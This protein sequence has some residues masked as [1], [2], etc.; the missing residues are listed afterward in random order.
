M[1]IDKLKS[2]IN[3]EVKYSVDVGFRNDLDSFSQALDENNY[4]LDWR[5][6]PLG[7]IVSRKW[8]DAENNELLK[9]PKDIFERFINLIGSK[10]IPQKVLLRKTFHK[11]TNYLTND[12]ALLAWSIR[13]LSRAVA[14]CCP[15]KYNSELMSFG[16][17]RKV[18]QL[19]RFDDGPLRA[20]SYLA[21]HG[22]SLIIE[23]TL[24]GTK[25]NG[26]SLMTT[27]GMPIVGL[28]LLYD[29]VDNFWFTLLHELAHI[30]KHLHSDNDLY[31]DYFGGNKEDHLDSP[32][33]KEAD[34]IAREA[35]IPNEYMTHDAFIFQSDL[36]VKE[37]ANELK[38]HTS[39][40]A[41]RI[42]Y[43]NSAWHILSDYVSNQT[44]RRLFQDVDWN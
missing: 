30:W 17:L 29:R 6:F 33:E 14:E 16:F 13:V 28:T 2:L 39:I 32:N 43:D 36:A 9:K 26:A 11:N 22:I 37:L 41:G 24:T 4:S 19:S 8:I 20:K 10:D 1:N 7:E 23:K 15:K 27:S 5:A 38:I 31:I 35:L 44:V 21:D 34:K 3:D 18:A 25:F 42:R 12:Y 40:I